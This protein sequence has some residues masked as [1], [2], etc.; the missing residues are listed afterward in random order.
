MTELRGRMGSVRLGLAMMA[1]G[2][3]DPRPT[4]EPARAGLD[5]YVKKPDS[6]FAWSQIGN[7]IHA[8]R[9]RSPSSS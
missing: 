1:V 4:T 9:E 2:S 8:G 7:R 6:A 3:P 5:E